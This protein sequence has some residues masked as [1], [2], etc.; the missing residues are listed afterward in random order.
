[1]K[2]HEALF[3]DG[4]KLRVEY[5]SATSVMKSESFRE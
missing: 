4:R 1:M 3:R 2:W 5:F